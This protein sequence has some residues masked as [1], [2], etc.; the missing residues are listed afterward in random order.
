MI[1]KMNCVNCGNTDTKKAIEYDGC[2]G[3]EAIICTV[4]G[5]YSDHWGN[6]SP[7]E[8]SKGYI[9]RNTPEHTKVN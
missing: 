3:Y 5:E 9:K 6:H 2:L 4:C 1:I 7:D 8:W